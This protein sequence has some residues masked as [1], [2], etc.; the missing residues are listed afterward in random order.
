MF[1]VK[2]T[3]LPFHLQRLGSQV[4]KRDVGNWSKEPSNKH[5]SEDGDVVS[6]LPYFGAIYKRSTSRS[7]RFV[8]RKRTL[9]RNQM[10]EERKKKNADAI[11]RDVEPTGGDLAMLA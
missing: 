5:K 8:Q 11:T 2:G 6:L 3:A 10:N 4:Q 7:G 9:V 1:R